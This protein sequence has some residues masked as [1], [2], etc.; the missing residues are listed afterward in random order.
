MR[1]TC[2]CI[3]LTGF[4]TR[5]NSKGIGVIE[6]C[7][8]CFANEGCVVSLFGTSTTRSIQLTTLNSWKLQSQLSTDHLELKAMIQPTIAVSYLVTI[9]SF[10]LLHI[11][12]RAYANPK[13]SG[14]QFHLNSLGCAG[15]TARCGGSAPFLNLAFLILLRKSNLQEISSSNPLSK[16][17]SHSQL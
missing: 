8:L 14:P 15:V 10:I 6:L 9:I 16:F 7:S 11:K 4:F 5:L 2:V 1:A 3:C 12:I 13:L 17:A